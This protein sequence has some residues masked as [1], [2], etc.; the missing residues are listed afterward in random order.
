[1]SFYKEGED[2]EITYTNYL[3]KLFPYWIITHKPVLSKAD[4]YSNMVHGDIWIKTLENRNIAGLDCKKSRLI[5]VK[6]I[7]NFIG[8]KNS[9]KSRALY[10]GSDFIL[11]NTP[12]FKKFVFDNLIEVYGKPPSIDHDRYYNSVIQSIQRETDYKNV[13]TTSTFFEIM[14]NKTTSDIGVN[15]NFLPKN[16][17]LTYDG[18]YLDIQYV[19]CLKKCLEY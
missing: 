2:F 4:V 5:S 14:P 1:M 11:E 10:V 16:I 3:N 13:N 7:A 17:S 19:N 15:L 8:L 9:L 6:S 12:T 18:N